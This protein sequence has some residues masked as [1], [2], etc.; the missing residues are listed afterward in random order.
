M[1][2][3]AIHA[4]RALRESI[5]THA[6]KAGDDPVPAATVDALGRAGLWGVMTPRAVGGREL[7]LLEVLDVF[8]EVARADGSA[9]W[10]LM[11]G[12]SA[13][14]Y[15]GAYAGDDFVE[16]L[17]ADGVPLVAGQFAP[18]GTGTREGGGYRISGRYQ[19][20][21]GMSYAQWVGAGF[22]V[23]PP[24][25]SDAPAEYRFGLV[26]RSEVEPRGN[27]DV[28]GLAS[29][30]SWDYSIDD[31]LVPEDATF[32]FAAPTRRRGGPVY[33]VGVIALTALGHSGFALG[34]A[35]RALDELT[36]V[37]KTKVRMGA[38]SFLKDSESFLEKLGVLESRFR[39]MRAWVREAFAKLEASASET[40]QVDPV[41]NNEVR[42][43]TVFATQQA[44]EVV[45][46]AYL[47]AGTTALR[48]GPLERCFRDI[49]A[50]SQHFFASPAS[51]LDMAR[52]LLA[53]APDSALDA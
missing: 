47:L 51:T 49:H 35:R 38:G 29:T 20:G 28:L 8:E 33:S 26:P 40:G 16:K 42:Q 36:V 39:A 15:F 22:L 41:Q 10:C 5:D 3:T 14:A 30:A 23:P 11:A 9:G 46:G 19:F 17:F 21:S 24:E 6:R 34:V 48:A 13:V 50:G 18:N 25:G 12:A 37:S 4:A 53:A 31:A 52:D 32:L 44:A 1:Q 2:E 45:R 27:W 7:P 43:A